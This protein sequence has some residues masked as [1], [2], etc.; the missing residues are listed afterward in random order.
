M[1]P[2]C[3]PKILGSEAPGPSTVSAFRIWLHGFFAIETR[4][5]IA[6]G[7]RHPLLRGTILKAFSRGV[8]RQL[9]ATQS[10]GEVFLGFHHLYGHW[11]ASRAAHVVAGIAH[12][13]GRTHRHT[14]EGGERQLG[15]IAP[16]CRP[17]AHRTRNGAHQR[18]Q[19]GGRFFA[20]TRA[21]ADGA[22]IVLSS[23]RE[24]G[25]EAKRI[26]CHRVASIRSCA[27]SY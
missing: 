23:R 2:A 24:L 15:W 20:G 5:E 9:R 12:G 25:N 13:C 8:S 6:S 10:L 21:I 19:H 22:V 16:K 17:G 4:S 1:F 14:F 27:G 7:W 3:G 11:A 18:G 26:L